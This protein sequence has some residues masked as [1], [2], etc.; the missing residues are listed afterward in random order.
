M[1][2]NYN[3]L[4]EYILYFQHRKYKAMIRK[5][6]LY[7]FLRLCEENSESCKESL[8]LPKDTTD[9]MQ[10]VNEALM[11]MAKEGLIDKNG[12]FVR[13]YDFSSVSYLE[14]VQMEISI[15]VLEYLV[16]Q[17]VCA[18]ASILD[19]DIIEAYKRHL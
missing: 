14:E 3:K 1:G 19:N 15:K 2:T 7:D 9:F 4:K 10:E 13:D 8:K 5:N 12:R 6:A 18:A 11:Q 16:E 17:E